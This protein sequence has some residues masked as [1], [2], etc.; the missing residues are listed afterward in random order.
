MGFFGQRVAGP[1]RIDTSGFDSDALAYISAVE[2]ADDQQLEN[3]ILSA[4][5]TFISGLKTDNVWAD[6][7][8]A[9]ILSGA[10]TLTGAL[11][12]LKGPAPTS[13]NF[14]SGDYI[15]F[16]GLRGNTSTKYIDSGRAND[17][18]GTQD[19]FHMAAFNSILLSNS[20]RASIMGCASHN[21]SGGS[22]FN[23]A[24]TAIPER[25]FIACRTAATNQASVTSRYSRFMGVSRSAS[26]S[27]DYVGDMGSVTVATISQT[28]AAGNI[29]IFASNNGGTAV[30]Y[31]GDV[32]LMFYS[33]G[34]ATTLTSIRDRLFT[35]IDSIRGT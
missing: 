30:Q 10:R 5:N 16:G 2:T 21:V 23:S 33:I 14:V 11:T 9:C 27:F 15:R 31:D 26:A 4:I 1:A 6:I 34:T 18:S 28:P 7:E 29:Y 19:D 35:F 12:P 17:A 3:Y 24:S 25:G 8:A 22:Y 13:Y 20:A 32:R